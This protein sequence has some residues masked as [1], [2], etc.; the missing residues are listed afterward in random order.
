MER[1]EEK[2]VRDHCHF[3]GK[4]R[5]AAHNS[6]DVRLRRSKRIPVIFHNFTGYDNH[7]FVKSLGKIEGEISVIVRNEEKHISVTKDILI[8]DSEK[9]Q[10]R[11]SDSMSFMCGSLDSHVSNLRSVGEEKFRFTKAHFPWSVKFQKVIRKGVFP[12]EW[13]THVAHLNQ[14]CLPKKDQ[15][16]SRLSSTGINESDY[17]HAKD[18]WKT[19]GMTTMREYHDLYLKTDVLLLTDVFENFRDMALEHFGVDPC[20]YVTAPGMFYDAL[21]KTSKVEL[22]LVSDSEMYDFIERGKRGGVSSI[23]KRYA[24]ANNRHMGDRYDP[25]KPSSYIFYPDANSLYCW[26]MLQDLPVGGF[27]WLDSAELEKSL[28]DFPPCFVSVDLEFP[29]ELHDKFKDY[30]PAPDQLKLVGVKKLAPNLLPK[31]EYVA[32]IPNIRKYEELGCRITKVHRALAFDESP[33]MRSYVE[34]NIEK[35]KLAENSFE[36]DFWKLA[37]NS[38]F[39]KT[40][41]NVMNRVNVRLVNERKKALKLVAKPNFKQHTIYNESLVGIQMG[42]TKVKLNKPSYVGVAILDLSKILMFDFYYDFVQPTWGP[43][44]EVLFTDTDSLALHVFTEDLYKDIELHVDTW[45]DTSKLK[46]G[47]R[48]GL[49]V[50]KNSGIVGKFKDEEPNDVITEFVGVRAKNYGYTTLGGTEKKKDKGIKKA[51]IKREITFDDFK[52]CV[53]NGVVKHV[54]QNTIRSRKH[55][56]FTESLCKKAL[57]PK[58]DKRVVLEDRMHTLPIGHRGTRSSERSEV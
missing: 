40:C 28:S 31:T 25:S 5:G 4:F 56:V 22:E 39:G 27:R 51:V 29:E 49:P 47:N 18:V 26:P 41:E 12:Y 3:T 38:V 52:D 48:Q 24:E 45:F 23:M 20:H 10:L 44:A 34:R 11:F 6:C 43:R 19:F 16:F 1:Y 32:Y 7:L 21:L 15:F 55:E 36:K 30:P 17:A 8:E 42:V 9:W 50:G 58:D 35:R 54:T 33:W 53:L 46:P 57:C 14:N 2:V 13:L 37:N